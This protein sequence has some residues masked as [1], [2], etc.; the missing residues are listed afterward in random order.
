MGFFVKVLGGH[1]IPVLKFMHDLSTRSL[2]DNAVPP[3]IAITGNKDTMLVVQDGMSSALDTDSICA[4]ASSGCQLVAIAVC[5]HLLL[6]LDRSDIIP[7]KGEGFKRKL[8]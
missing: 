6:I 8:F 4:V 7:A 5:S 2:N 3:H 1:V